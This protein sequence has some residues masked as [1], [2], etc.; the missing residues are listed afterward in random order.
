M[1]RE[2][3]KRGKKHKKNTQD[4]AHIQEDLNTTHTEPEVGEPSWIRPAPEDSP[5]INI[6]APF[7]YVDADVKAYFR[8]VDDQ[9]RGWQEADESRGMTEEIKTTDPNE[10]TPS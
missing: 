1:P 6:D 7:G 2:H 5:E 3:R 4:E 10:G 8:T 9:I